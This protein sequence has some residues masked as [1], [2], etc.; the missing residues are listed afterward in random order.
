MTA[1]IFVT[2]RDNKREF[3][4]LH[5]ACTCIRLPIKISQHWER[6]GAVRLIQEGQMTGG[7]VMQHH[8]LITG[9]GRS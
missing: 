4:R 6:V 8:L 2:I 5:L 9:I 1:S 7:N 3:N